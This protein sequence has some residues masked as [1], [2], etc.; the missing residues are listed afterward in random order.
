MRKHEKE[1]ARK[2]RFEFGK[3]WARFLS[4][5]NDK[6]IKA[7]EESLKEKLEVENL[8]GKKFLDIGSGS[9]LFSLAAKRLG[10]Q[11][12]SFDYD[13]QSIACTMELK[14]RYFPNDKGWVIEEG[15]VLDTDYLV[16]LGTFDVVYSWGVL[17][18][19]GN[20]WQALKNVV[21]LVREEGQLFIAIYNDQG[22]VSRYWLKVKRFYNSGFIGKT[23]MILFHLPYLLGVRY[24]IRLLTGR[25]HIER[26][27]SMWY[28]MLDWLG[29]YPFEVSPPEKIISFY[30][31]KK[32]ILHGLKI[33]QGQHGCNEFIFRKI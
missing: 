24:S 12:Y 14:R 32:F 23:L 17:H 1:V 9:G 4:V 11:V 21:S 28:D 30:R 22:W 33:F 31:R 18:H 10:A 16:R 6:R 8:K 20:M 29:G 7:A 25:L 2:Q 19:T 5:L 26:G 13:P 3:N 27:M 15:S